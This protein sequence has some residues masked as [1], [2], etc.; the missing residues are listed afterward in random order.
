MAL[1]PASAGIIG[2]KQICAS[3][4]HVQ[5]LANRDIA[6]NEPETSDMGWDCAPGPAWKTPRVVMIV[7]K[8]VV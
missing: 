8:I 6:V 7:E 3:R 2:L 1:G 4:R 5:A